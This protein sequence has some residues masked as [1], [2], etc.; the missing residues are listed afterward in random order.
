LIRH[1]Y[2]VL[3]AA[4]IG[5]AVAA[6][7]VAAQSAPSAPSSPPAPPAQPQPQPQAAPKEPPRPP[8]EFKSEGEFTGGTKDSGFAIEAIRFG[9]HPD[10]T[11]IVLDLLEENPTDKFKFIPARVH[12]VYRIEYKPFPYRVNV[13][14][15]G[16][17]FLNST[18]VDKDAA[19][20]FSLVTPPDN[21][22]KQMTFFL[23][24]P[25]LFKVMEVDDPA[26]I[27]IDVKPV[28]GAKVPTV[29]ALSILDVADVEGAFKLVEE[30]KFPPKFH[31]SVVVL[32]SAFFVEDVY[33]SLSDATE[34][35]A[36]LEKAGFETLI[37]ERAGNELPHK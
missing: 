17:K 16:V 20:P 3:V 10:F 30:G 28:E 35:S 6:S 33:T 9:K 21:V 4:L 12:P 1:W 13:F 27:V 19:L 2:A 11:R 15:T 34:I 5:A 18:R 14:L 22:V 36:D 29:Y 23:P 26:K 8:A 37:S 24:G 32:G 25:S 7:A 31:P